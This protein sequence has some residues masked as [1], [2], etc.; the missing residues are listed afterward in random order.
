MF[1]SHVP[2]KALNTHTQTYTPSMYPDTR[3]TNRL[4]KAKLEKLEK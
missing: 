3:Q 1:M 2:V 4:Q